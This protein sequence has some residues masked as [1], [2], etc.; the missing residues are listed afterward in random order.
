M[1]V[2]NE[3]KIDYSFI[4]AIDFRRLPYLKVFHLRINKLGIKDLNEVLLKIFL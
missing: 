1:S 3:K 2:S 4:S